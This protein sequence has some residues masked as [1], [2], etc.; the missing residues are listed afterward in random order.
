[1]Y[2]IFT[3]IVS[4]SL[5]LILRN[6]LIHN[7]K[8]II[9][10]INNN[11][12]NN[13]SMKQLT[14]FKLSQFLIIFFIILSPGFFLSVISAAFLKKF[15]SSM[16]SALLVFFPLVPSFLAFCLLLFVLQGHINITFHCDHIL[17]HDLVFLIK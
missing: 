11:N 2:T 7:H 12:N 1:M 15:P 10:I 16:S 3:S 5:V 9:N 17:L 14:L 8:V 6:F 4:V 13:N